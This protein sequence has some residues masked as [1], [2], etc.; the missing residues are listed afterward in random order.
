MLEEEVAQKATKELSKLALAVIIPLQPEHERQIKC[1]NP[2]G[3]CVREA[4]AS[5]HSGVNNSNKHVD[6]V[7][8]IWG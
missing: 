7:C 5:A 6:F 8:Q 2:H 1:Q 4:N 3:S